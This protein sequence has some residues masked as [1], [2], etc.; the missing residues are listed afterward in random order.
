MSEYVDW[1][2][3]LFLY[4]HHLQAQQRQLEEQ[5]VAERRLGLEDAYGIVE[6]ELKPQALGNSLVEF[7]RLQVI[8]HSGLVID[9]PGNANLNAL[10]IR[11]AVGANAGRGSFTVYLGVPRLAL[12]RPNAPAWE[13]GAAAANIHR[14]MPIERDV[15]DENSGEGQEKI[16]FRRINAMLLLENHGRT[17]LEELIPVL[18]ISCGAGPGAKPQADPSYVPPCVVVGGSDALRSVIA[19]LDH[20]VQAIRRRLAAQMAASGF[21]TAA[22]QGARLEQLLRLGTLNRFAVR[23]PPLWRQRTTTPRQAYLQLRE[24]QAD[25][26]A[27]YPER[28]PFDAPDYNHDD[29]LPAFTALVGKIRPMLDPHGV[30]IF[31]VPFVRQDAILVA[32]MLPQHFALPLEYEYYL[33][34]KSERPVA[35][36]I[37]LVE[38]RED[39]RLLPRKQGK[40][41]LLGIT[42]EYSK[43]P[44]VNVPIGPDLHYFRMRTSE[45]PDKW[46]QA[47]AESGLAVWV[48]PQRAGTLVQNLALHMTVPAGGLQR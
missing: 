14:Y 1:Y 46:E 3:G 43:I 13:E 47:K 5:F 17:D 45:N 44:P 9:V 24:M 11:E 8:T 30:E 12:G 7:A 37:A 20:E 21:T 35:E 31:T 10:P 33:G 36:V 34:V 29:P 42:L 26:A 41:R 32:D 2:E 40:L 27:L 22:A 48:N 38:N 18:K 15:T 19:E 39:F 25:L 6:A 23:L 16:R 28:D 4:P